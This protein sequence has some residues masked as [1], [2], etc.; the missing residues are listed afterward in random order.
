MSPVTYRIFVAGFFNGWFEQDV[1]A[2]D[3]SALRERMV[4]EQLV[5]L[6]E[7]AREEVWR[8]KTSGNSA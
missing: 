8:A 4:E 7:E 5:A 6:F 1:P 2:P 3:F